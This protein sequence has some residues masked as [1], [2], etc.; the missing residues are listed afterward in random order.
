MVALHGR[1]HWLGKDGFH[2]SSAPQLLS[3]PLRECPGKRPASP[4]E[5]EEWEV[6]NSASLEYIYLGS[7]TGSQNRV[8]G[9]KKKSSRAFTY[10]ICSQHRNL[11]KITVKME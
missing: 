9:F 11:T 6:N 10:E 1:N 2:S 5:A 3:L 7:R 8:T 4:E